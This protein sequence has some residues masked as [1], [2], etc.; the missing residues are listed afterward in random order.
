M[1][2]HSLNDRKNERHYEEEANILESNDDKCEN[3]KKN[4]LTKHEKLKNK[5]QEFLSKTTADKFLKEAIYVI[6][7]AKINIYQKIY[8]LVNKDNEEW[9]NFNFLSS[10]SKR[11]SFINSLQRE[12]DKVGNKKF[13]LDKYKKII[14]SILNIPSADLFN[15]EIL[16]NMYIAKLQNIIFFLTENDGGG[17]KEVKETKQDITR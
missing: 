3:R 16:T 8:Q 1:P 13:N 2:L 12:I 4:R 9:C 5:K 11:K 7:N 14:A 15:D 6:S 10:K 17:A